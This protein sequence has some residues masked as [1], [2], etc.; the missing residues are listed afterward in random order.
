MLA[1]ARQDATVLSKGSPCMGEEVEGT[2]F[3]DIRK[4]LYIF[5]QKKHPKKKGGC[6]LLWR[7]GL[8][9]I[10][11]HIVHHFLL[12]VRRTEVRVIGPTRKERHSDY[13]H[14]SR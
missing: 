2:A 7:L 4:S 5:I 12:N 9:N 3:F 13:Q 6:S 8:L 1:Y 10:C 11:L 14:D